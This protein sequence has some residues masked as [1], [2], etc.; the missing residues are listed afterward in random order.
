MIPTWYVLT[1][2]SSVMNVPGG[3]V[4]R[5]AW[6]AAIYLVFIPDVW[7]DHFAERWG[8]PCRNDDGSYGIA[9]HEGPQ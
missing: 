3:C 7:W 9:A 5:E 8:V 6:G 1:G 2:S 4:Y